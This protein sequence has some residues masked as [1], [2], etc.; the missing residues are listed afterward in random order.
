MPDRRRT[1]EDELEAARERQTGLLRG[2]IDRLRTL[3]ETSQK[4]IGLDQE[5]FRAAISCALA[6]VRAGLLRANAVERGDSNGPP[7]FHFPAV[8]ER[9]GGVPLLGRYHGHAPS[10]AQTR[11]EILGVASHLADSAGRV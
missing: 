8:D 9:Q 7:R 6:F 3:L 4:S 11:S 1:V 10:R 5:Q 2:Q